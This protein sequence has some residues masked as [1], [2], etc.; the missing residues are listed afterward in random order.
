[1]KLSYYALNRCS[2]FTQ[3]VHVVYLCAS[4]MN[5]IMTEALSLSSGGGQIGNQQPAPSINSNV[6][7]YISSVVSKIYMEN[8][9]LATKWY[10]LVIWMV[11]HWYMINFFCCTLPL[12]CHITHYTRCWKI[13]KFLVQQTVFCLHWMHQYKQNQLKQ[14][15]IQLQQLQQLQKFLQQRQSYVE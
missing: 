1:M 7:V 2:D 3:L 11:K 15:M 12:Y 14:K 6:N 5:I 4:D 10:I 8:Y 9:I 13:Y